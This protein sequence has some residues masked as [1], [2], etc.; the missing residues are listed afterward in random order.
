MNVGFLHVGD[1]ARLAEI[2]VES[3]RRVMPGVGIVQMTDETTPAVL[4]VDM[5]IRRPYDGV[6]LMTY[7][8]DHL[9]ALHPADWLILDTDVVVQ[10]CVRHVFDSMLVY[11]AVALTRRYG[12][13]IGPGGVNIVELMPYNT[14]VMFVRD[15]RFFARA[16]AACHSF[17]EHHQRWWG[18][19]LAVKHVVDSGRSIVELPCDTYNYSPSSQDEDVSDKAVLHFKGPRKPWMLTRGISNAPDGIRCGD[20]K[21]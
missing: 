7:R 5:V 9:A 21:V 10:K 15:I 1:D 6:H 20:A 13:I 8:L 18:D 17:P 3:V 4:G 11:D 16:A 12:T 19:Q 2:M 14:G